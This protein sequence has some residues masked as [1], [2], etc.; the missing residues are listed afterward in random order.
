MSD[1]D[2]PAFNTLAG[3]PYDF[4]EDGDVICVT[5][6]AEVRKN[7]C[8]VMGRGC[9]EFVRDTFRGSDKK[10]GG[11]LKSYGNRVFRLGQHHYRGKPFE[12]VT[13]PTKNQWRDKSDLALIRKSAQEL[14][15]LCNKFGYAKIYIP[16][17]GCSNGYLRWSQV[18]KELTDLDSR[19]V[20]YSLNSADFD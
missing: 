3:N 18:R 14:V 12:L 1:S 7:G 9:A 6:N 20:V 16:I 19:F 10:L 8:A 11:Y 2:K 15:A 4:F 17:P 5:T 13:F